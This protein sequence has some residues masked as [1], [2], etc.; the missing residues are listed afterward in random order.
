MKTKILIQA[1]AFAAISA[2]A[3]ALPPLEENARVNHDFLS[4]AVGDEIRKNCP[5]ISA[6]MLRVLKRANDLEEYA[7]SLGYT[8]ADIDEMRQNPDAKARLR[9]NRDAYL[10]K[11]GVI[12]GDADSY[13]RLGHAEIEKKTLTGWLLRAK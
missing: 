5:D 6:R 2:P 9:A 11:N 12:E 4:A 10:A 3:F 1:A 8:K 13:C 7:I